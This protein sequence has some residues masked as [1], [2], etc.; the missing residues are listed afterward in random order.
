L[1][2]TPVLPLPFGAVVS[3]PQTVVWTTLDQDAGLA[4]VTGRGDLVGL[5]DY[6][7]LRG[8]ARWSRSGRGHVIPLDRVADLACAADWLSVPY[9]ERQRVAS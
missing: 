6:A 2:T 8:V 4:L 1:G 3:G 5:L 9:R 7:G